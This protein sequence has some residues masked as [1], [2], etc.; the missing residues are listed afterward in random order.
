MRGCLYN[1]LMPGSN[2]FRINKKLLNTQINNMR[3]Y[4]TEDVSLS[5]IPLCHYRCLIININY[6]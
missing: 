4:F 6:F 1:A 2:A 5:F 3:Q